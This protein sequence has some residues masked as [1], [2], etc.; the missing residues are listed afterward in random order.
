MNGA[1]QPRGL[2]EDLRQRPENVE[3][4]R[5]ETFYDDGVGKGGRGRLGELPDR[6]GDHT[7]ESC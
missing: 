7:L 1:H 6:F 5:D 2:Q 4:A 3:V